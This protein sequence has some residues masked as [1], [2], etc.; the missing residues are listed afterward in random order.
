LVSLKLINWYLLISL[1]NIIFDKN[2]FE[3]LYELLNITSSNSGF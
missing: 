3:L 1:F 2:E